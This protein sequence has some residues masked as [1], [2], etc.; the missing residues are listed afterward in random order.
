MDIKSAAKVGLLVVIG[1][2]ALFWAWQFLSH[3]DPDVYTLYAVFEDVKGLQKQTPVRMNG[4]TIGEV[5][6]VGFAR[7]S[8][9]PRVT[10]SIKKKYERRIPAD[11]KIHITSGLLIQNSLVE[12][13]PGTSPVTLAANDYF[14]KV[15]QPAGMLAQMSPEAAER[16]IDSHLKS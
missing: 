3:S 8:L 5:A 16:L 10:M 15:E 2:A 14:T 12:I 4:V 6:D 9:K 1:T 13:I 11:S 7:G